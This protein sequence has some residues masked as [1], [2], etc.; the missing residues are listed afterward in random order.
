MTKFAVNDFVLFQGNGGCVRAID[1]LSNYKFL[2]EGEDEY[3]IE[4]GYPSDLGHI[5]LPGC[6]YKGKWVVKEGDGAWF[7]ESQLTHA[8]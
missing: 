7:E 2:T 6:L 5:E 3:A 4:F 8:S 1:K